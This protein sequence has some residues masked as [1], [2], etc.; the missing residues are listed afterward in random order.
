MNEREVLEQVEE[1]MRLT[2]WHVVRTHRHNKAYRTA[3]E[4]ISDLIATKQGRTVWIETKGTRGTQS[5]PQKQ[6][7]KEI[8]DAGGEYYVVRSLDDLLRAIG[9]E[10]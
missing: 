4:G 8:K 5:E 6:F 10:N 9:G 1:Y 2:G 7:E 3:V